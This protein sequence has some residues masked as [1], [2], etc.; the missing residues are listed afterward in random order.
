MDPSL[1]SR[2]TRKKDLLRKSISYESAC[3]AESNILLQLSYPSKRLDFFFQLFE[4]QEEIKQ[5]VACHLGLKRN[6]S[7]RLG[8]FSEW[9][10]GTFNVCIP[11]YICNW[12]RRPKN[13]V[14][15][16]FPLPYKLGESSYPG[17]MDEKV[18]SEAATYVWMQQNCPEI[19]IPHLWGFG[20]GNNLHVRAV[21]RKALS[22]C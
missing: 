17:N 21:F 9:R 4:K 3:E 7:C 10:H 8:D 6:Q 18:R 22:I 13:R 14:L 5:V 11:V 19:P 12:N 2:I 20:I 15:I 1:S 16:R